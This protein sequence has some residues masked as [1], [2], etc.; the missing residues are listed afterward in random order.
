MGFSTAKSKS[1]RKKI[2]N[3]KNNSTANIKP[4]NTLLLPP[5]LS[6]F[7]SIMTTN[8]MV[9]FTRSFI[10]FIALLFAGT[11][12]HAQ[13][14][15]D[16]IIVIVGKNRIILNSELE[17][18]MA[19]AKAEDPTMHDSMKCQILERM[20][21]SKFLL[22]QADR[23]SVYVTDDDVEGQLDNNI[24]YFTRQYGSKENME[25][26]LG[27]TIY[28]IK[29][30]YREVYR[31]Q[32]LAQKMQG[33]LMQNV[34][35]TP[36]EV[37]EFFDNIVRSDSS[38]LIPIPAT[39]ELGQIVIDPPVSEELDK[40]AKDKITDIRKRIVEGGESFESLA[41]IYSNDPGSRDDGGSLGLIGRGDLVP[42]FSAAAFKLKDGEISPIV[43]TQF[44]YHIIQM[45][46]RQG[47]QAQLRHILIHPAITSGDI[48]KALNKLD[49]VRS[50]LISG[51]TTFQLA[52]GKY[53]T[54]ENS[55][56]TGGMIAEPNT[57]ATQIELDKLDPAMLLMLDSLQ[58]GSY[59]QPQVFNNEKGEKSCR[60]VYV[61]SRIAPHQVN[62]K[63]DYSKIQEL[64]LQQKKMLQVEKWVEQKVP[65]YY[66]NIDPEYRSCGNLN[67]WYNMSAAAANK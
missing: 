55:K 19:A 36:A 4:L 64:A 61:K 12:L 65:T 67:K 30:E 23:D 2:V 59:S 58:A 27:K 50:E 44:G 26:A 51:K 16:K 62:L 32:L 17:K 38:A 66:L 35:I 49:S 5:Y 31:E 13:Q 20:V 1:N 54:D 40:D 33:Q 25:K 21:L 7:R 34:K 39:V 9:A 6:F 43:K 8:K 45:I 46:K 47:D 10:L 37:K 48:K 3:V 24:R 60:I 29:D 28:Q 11:Q 57:G 56:R 63:E 14:V 53:S 22:E 41:G 52:V 42:A 18:Q 15:A